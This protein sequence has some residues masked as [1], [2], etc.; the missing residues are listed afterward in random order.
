MT[1]IHATTRRT[2]WTEEELGAAVGAYLKMLRIE[3]GGSRVVKKR[4]NEELRAGVLANRSQSAVEYR[5][6]NI[7]R[8]LDDLGL[9]WIDGYRPASN[10]GNEVRRKIEA[11]IKDLGKDLVD[12][13]GPTTDP[14]ELSRRANVLASTP[15]PQRSQAPE[16]FETISISFKRDPRVVAWVRR[17]AA[18]ICELCGQEAPFLCKEQPFLEVHHVVS[19]ADGGIDSVENAV[20]VCPNCHRRLHLSDEGTSPTKRLYKNVR[21]LERPDTAE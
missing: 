4:V 12:R 8:V 6:R 3:I 1:K 20:A 5:M 15:M 7:S 18:G 2:D 13:L 21:R 14:E 11:Q 19:L 9:P 16:K 10:V 17:Q